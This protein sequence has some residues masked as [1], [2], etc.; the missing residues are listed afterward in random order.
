M[1]V[2]VG[3]GCHRANLRVL[4]SYALLRSRFWFG[5]EQAGSINGRL[6]Q[7]HLRLTVLYLGLF[8]TAENVLPWHSEPES[9]PFNFETPSMVRSNTIIPHVLS[10]KYQSVRLHR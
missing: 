8:P 5:V 6:F 3:D 10:V 7:N 4:A 9:C 1:L 2:S